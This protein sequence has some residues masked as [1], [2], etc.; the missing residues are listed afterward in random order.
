MNLEISMSENSDAQAVLD[1]YRP[2]IESSAVTFETAVPSLD[3]FKK[4]MRDV[5]KEAPWLVCRSGEMLLGYAYGGRHRVREAYRW[6]REV[7]VYIKE[8]YQGMGIASGLY[9][10]LIE[11]MRLQGYCNL[12]A[13]ITIPNPKSVGFHESMGFR[14]VGTYRNVGYKLGSFHDV[15]WWELFIGDKALAP[16]EITPPDE[17]LGTDMGKKALVLGME[18]IRHR[19]DRKF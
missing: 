18:M 17:V 16:S 5:R 19:N 12:L 15:G 6:S 13:G 10:S 9:S 14:H 4:R 1:I 7:S 8:G 3:S 2:F 11:L